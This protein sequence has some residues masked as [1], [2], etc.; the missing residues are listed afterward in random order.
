MWVRLSGVVSANPLPNIPIPTYSPQPPQLYQGGAMKD[1]LV[2]VSLK[3][4]GFWEVLVNFGDE[5][6]LRLGR[7]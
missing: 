6:D 2:F 1:F 7:S 4:C 3:V 5:K